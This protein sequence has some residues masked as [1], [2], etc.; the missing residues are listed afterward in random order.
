MLG[1]AGVGLA[2]S[3]L[4]GAAG[5]AGGVEPAVAVP[6]LRDA[7]ARAGLVYGAA[8]DE[9]FRDA[10]AKYRQLFTRQCALFAPILS[11]ADLAP[12]SAHEDDQPDPNVAVALDAGLKI[13]GAHLLWY[14]RTPEWLETLPRAQAERAAAL[15][16]QRLAGFYRGRCFSWNVVNEAIQPP[17]GAADGLRVKSAL[18]RAL[19]P[20]FF[21]A[22]FHGARAA[23]PGALLL[24]N[25][26]DLE[27][28]APDQ[29]AADGAFQA[30]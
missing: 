21:E 1:A 18:V 15:H 29:E 30:A 11:W 25:E 3:R 19:G 16:I 26:Y 10:P 13:T 6:V 20:G 23:D 17:E 22:A 2:S 28:A 12:D 14:L 9:R 4:V 24:Y 27:L 8:S 5:Q 7:A